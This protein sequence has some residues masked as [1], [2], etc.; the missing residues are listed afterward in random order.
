MQSFSDFEKLLLVGAY[1]IADETGDDWVNIRDIVKRYD[2]FYKTGWPGR[3]LR[4]LIDTG[5]SDDARHLGGDDLDQSISLTPHG[6][7]RG[8]ELQHYVILRERQAPPAEMTG[9]EVSSAQR[10]NF[11]PASDRIVLLSD[12]QP[13]LIEARASVASLGE[14]LKTG[15]DLGELTEDEIE[16]ARREVW[17]LEQAL[18]NEAVRVDWIEP[19]AKA[20][21]KWIAAKAAEQVVGTLAL[22]ALAALAA[23]FGFAV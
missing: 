22:M 19:L 7:K 5:Y 16:E 11:V 12:N 15:N 18:Q 10:S 2:I 14:Q 9:Q 20:C 8:E 4:S 13:Q 1:K 21:L 3:A 17:F 23:F 6:F